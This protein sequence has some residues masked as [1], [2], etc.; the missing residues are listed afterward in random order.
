[1]IISF[2]W[3]KELFGI[4]VR[5]RENERQSYGDGKKE[6]NYRVETIPP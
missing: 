3:S 5:R 6:K 1:M 2:I 4:R